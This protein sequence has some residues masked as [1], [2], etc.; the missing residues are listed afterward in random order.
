[1]PQ[2]AWTYWPAHTAPVPL[3]VVWCSFPFE[4]KK[5]VKD[6]PALVRSLA[7]YASQTK[8]LV[9]VAYGTSKLRADTRDLD[10]VISNNEAMQCAGLPQATRF[11]LDRCL[12]LP[13]VKEFFPCREGYTTPIIGH[14]SP[15]TVEQLE[16][17]KAIRKRTA[18]VAREEFQPK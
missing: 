6:R 16:W 15:Q 13:W 12:K 18:Q 2:R 11:D 17:L 5:A 4:D 3:D 7:F 8:L 14:L 10:L 9:E 1:M